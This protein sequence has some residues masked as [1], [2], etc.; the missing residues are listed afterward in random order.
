MKDTSI[1]LDIIFI[2]TQ[3]VVIA[4]EQGEPNSEEYIECVAD[5]GEL[6]RYVLEVNSGAGIQVGD[7]IDIKNSEDAGLDVADKAPTE[8][9]SDDM[10]GIEEISDEE[11]R[12][13]ILDSEGN[14]VH[15]VESG[16]RIFSRIH[17]RE[18]I[19][20][21]KHAGKTKEDSDYKRVGKRLFKIFDIQGNQEPEYVDSPKEAK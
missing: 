5:E 6:I 7:K 17:T 9:D 3:G 20:L 13:F 8:D 15:E 4:T 18:L 14:P 21:A 11:I 19:R 16:V 1:P 12:M 2:D 10:D